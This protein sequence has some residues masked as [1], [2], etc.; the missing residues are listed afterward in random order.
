MKLDAIDFPGNEADY[1]AVV[2]AGAGD[3][4]IHEAIRCPR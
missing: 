2:D 3:R 1:Q 4:D